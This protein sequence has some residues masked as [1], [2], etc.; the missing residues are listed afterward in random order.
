MR[1]TLYL[2]MQIRLFGKHEEINKGLEQYVSTNLINFQSYTSADFTGDCPLT[3]L[4]ELYVCEEGYAFCS[5]WTLGSLGECGEGLSKT[6]PE[7]VRQIKNKTGTIKYVDAKITPLFY[8]L[9]GKHTVNEEKL[10][11]FKEAVIEGAR[12]HGLHGL[13][14][15]VGS[16][17]D[18]L[19]G[20][21]A[22][23]FERGFSEEE[24]KEF[25]RL[26]LSR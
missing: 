15:E 16:S 25:E 13:E 22:Q 14:E 9:E 26:Y 20:A 21:S 4:V 2:K 11:D 18:R 8:T 7:L 1:N 6:I 5:G 24:R 3:L 17:I 12:Q 23:V 10:K 19:I